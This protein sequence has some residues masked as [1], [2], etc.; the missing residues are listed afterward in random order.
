M[1]A[2]STMVYFTIARSM[3]TLGLWIDVIVVDESIINWTAVNLE[4][5][6]DVYLVTVFL[7]A[8]YQTVSLADLF[9]GNLVNVDQATMGLIDQSDVNLVD[10]GLMYLA[11]SWVLVTA[12]VLCSLCS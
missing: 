8:V 12:W 9:D 1:V 4:K 2:I 5:L 3:A 6:F 10:I 11:A 7:T